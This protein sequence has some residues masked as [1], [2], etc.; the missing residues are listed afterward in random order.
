[1]KKLTIERQ[2]ELFYKIN[3]LSINLQ[4]S[5]NIIQNQ[6]VE[7]TK[8]EY[9]EWQEL[10]KNSL[11]QMVNALDQTSEF[12]YNNLLKKTDETYKIHNNEEDKA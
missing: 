10:V 3:E 8:E 11:K 9:Q 6:D 2:K 4:S 1:M 12:V 7:V 5:A